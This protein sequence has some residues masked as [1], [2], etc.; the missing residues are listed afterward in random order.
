MNLVIGGLQVHEAEVERSFGMSVLV[1]DMLQ[2]NGLIDGAQVW[3]KACLGGRS[4]LM[5]LCVLD[6]ALY[7]DA[8]I[9]PADGLSHCNW[10]VV[11]GVS[12]ITFLE[13]G[14]IREDFQDCGT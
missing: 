11:G 12:G 8:S 10:P 1:N 6:Q 9:Q 5:I 14:V 7:E 3:P 13:I 2:R 4:K